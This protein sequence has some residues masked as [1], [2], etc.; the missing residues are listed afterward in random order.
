MRFIY[1]YKKILKEFVIII[2]A[3]DYTQEINFLPIKWD[4]IP[5]AK[6]INTNHVIFSSWVF[7]LVL[8]GITPSHS[9]FSTPINIAQ[10]MY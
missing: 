5:K 8:R 4:D 2:P 1:V 10:H 9:T 7:I 6:K 3:F